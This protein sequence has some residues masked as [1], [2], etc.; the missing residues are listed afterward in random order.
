MQSNLELKFKCATTF[1]L[2]DGG[3]ESLACVLMQK[4]QRNGKAEII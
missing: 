2:R 4:M 3:V 1:W